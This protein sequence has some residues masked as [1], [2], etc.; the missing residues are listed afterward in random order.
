MWLGLTARIT[1]TM[2]QAMTDQVFR[3]HEE[4]H[5]ESQQ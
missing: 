2:S 4:E 5:T 3:S 1:E